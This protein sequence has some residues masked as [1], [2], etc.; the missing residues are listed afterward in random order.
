VAVA[1]ENYRLSS[2]IREIATSEPFQMR[3]PPREAAK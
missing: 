1:R 2:L 3:R